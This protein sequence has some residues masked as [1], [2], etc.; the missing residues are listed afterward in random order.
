MSQATGTPTPQAVVHPRSSESYPR[1]AYAWYV[2]GVLTLAYVFSFIDRQIL[3]LLV[4]PIR[5]DLDISDTQ[6]SLLMGLS[7]A[8]F[9]TLFGIPLGRLADSRSR[10]AIIGVSMVLWSV[11]TA[12]CGLARHYWHLFVCRV[13]VGIGEAG[14]SPAA[15]SLISD[16]FRPER[17]STALSV[18]SIGIYI[19]SGLALILG[20]VVVQFASERGDWVLPWLG[21][22][23]PWQL[24]FIIVGLPGILAALLLATVRE[25]ARQEVGPDGSGQAVPLREAWAYFRDNRAT[26]LCQNLGMSFIAL[27]GYGAGAWIPTLF[28][29]KFQWTP[30]EVGIIFGLIVGICGTLG[31][32]AGGRLADGMRQRG[33]ADANLRVALIGVLAWM[34]FGLLYPLASDPAGMLALIVPA[35]FFGSVPFGVGPACIQQ[36]V[37]NRLRGQASAV[38]LFVVNLIGLGLGPTA[39]ALVTD[40]VFHDD[41]AI[42]LSLLIVSLGGHAIAA[43]LLALGL[44]P[45]RRTINYLAAWSDAR[46]A[47]PTGL[48]S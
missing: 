40:R 5:R 20:G 2:V 6:M 17:R 10:R 27:V 43:T 44:R 8:V 12:G 1:P 23:R 31:V 9:Y 47:V 39:V 48:Q 34:P 28:V 29:R 14:L 41:Q 37:P 15:Y 30:G 33:R 46:V 19:G 26:F 38:Y 16:Y 7:F 24:V 4:G 35:V 11:M 21:A 45:Y 18:Y 42:H 22:L 32:V 13:G 25:P 36:M 3:N